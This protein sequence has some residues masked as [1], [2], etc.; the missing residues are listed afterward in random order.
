[1]ALDSVYVAAE[2]ETEETM[3]QIISR[4][5]S[6]IDAL[7]FT[8]EDELLNILTQASYSIT[9]AFELQEEYDGGGGS[10]I[11]PCAIAGVY[12]DLIVYN[13]FSELGDL[14]SGSQT[15][16]WAMRAVRAVSKYALDNCYCCN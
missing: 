14:D 7:N 12:A 15:F 3:Q 2:R 4:G 6:R 13:Y 1:M 16:P 5:K 8:H 11:D 10:I 9:L